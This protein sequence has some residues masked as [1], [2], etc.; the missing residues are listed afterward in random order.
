MELGKRKRKILSVIVETYI[1]TGIPVGSKTV[2]KKLDFSVSSATVRNEMAELSELGYLEQPHTSAGRVPSN[3]GYRAYVSRLMTIK[4]VSA[5]EKSLISGALCESADDPERLLEE[6]S[7]ILANMTKLTSVLTTP[8]GDEARI[9]DIQFVRTG[10]RNAMVVLMT[11][12][13]MVK[14][15]LFRC[16]YDITPEIIE[17]FRGV[18]G[19]QFRGKSL[20]SITPELTSIISESRSDISVLLSPVLNAVMEAARDACKTRIRM[21]GQANL[22]MIPKISP[23]KVADIFEFLESSDNILGLLLSRE[24]GVSVFIGDESEFPELDESSV[25]VTRYSV[26]GRSGAIGIIGPT[27][28]DYAGLIAKLE[29]LASTIGTML[30]RILEIE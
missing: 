7:Q 15:R 2:C 1:E 29:Y 27:R 24:R 4:S 25:I 3:K 26:G 22:L 21:D 17:V 20:L 13:G 18:I 12:T 6:A 23:Y 11:T 5:D 19:E 14:N 10:R 8:L 30:G 16:E 28:M 9:R